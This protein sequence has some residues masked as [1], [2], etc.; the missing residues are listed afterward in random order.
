MAKSN[1]NESYD[2]YP[3]GGFLGKPGSGEAYKTGPWRTEMPKYDREKCTDC[4]LCWVF[5]PDLSIIVKDKKMTGID[6]DH[7]K[8]CG[9]CAHECPVAAIV[10]GENDSYQHCEIPG[11]QDA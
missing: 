3:G 8:G 11:S 10:M 2:K 5:C 4:M 6:Y 7:C 9:I 1:F